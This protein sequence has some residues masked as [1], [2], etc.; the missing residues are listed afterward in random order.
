MTH[1]LVLSNTLFHHLGAKKLMLVF[2]SFSLKG[3]EGNIKADFMQ[4]K[5]NYRSGFLMPVESCLE[6]E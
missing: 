5:A 1:L 3:W 6:T 2:F 4:S